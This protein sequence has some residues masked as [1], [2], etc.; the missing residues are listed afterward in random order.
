MNLDTTSSET[1]D[2][3]ARNGPVS[4]GGVYQEFGNVVKSSITEMLETGLIEKR[5]HGGHS[6]LYSIT[7]R[8]RGEWQKPVKH[9]IAAP[10]EST[11][12]YERYDGAELRPFTGRPHALDALE[13]PSVIQGSRVWRDGRREVVA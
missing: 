1:L 10:R 6:V 5:L 13:H 11:L 9:R 12:S 2:F 8:G 3:I 4:A 7:N